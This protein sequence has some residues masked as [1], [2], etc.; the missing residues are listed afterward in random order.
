VVLLL[1]GLIA[2]SHIFLEFWIKVGLSFKYPAVSRSK[3][4]EDG[5]DRSRRMPGE[6]LTCYMIS[7][8]LQKS[9]ARGVALG[10]RWS[11]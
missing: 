1:L 5:S 10:V 7:K 3:S 2:A 6:I 9:A 8:R 11:G 4:I